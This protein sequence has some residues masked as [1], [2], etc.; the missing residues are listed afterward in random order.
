MEEDLW[1]NLSNT[2]DTNTIYCRPRWMNGCPKI[3]WSG[4]SLKSSINSIGRNSPTA[5]R[6]AAPQPA[7][8]LM[9]ATALGFRQCG[10]RFEAVQHEVHE[11]VPALEAHAAGQ[12][13]DVVEQALARGQLLAEQ[14][15]LVVHPLQHGVGQEG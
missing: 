15:V 7:A 8:I 12:R 2:T 13:A 9:L 3:I 5:I 6:T 4:T 1:P 11:G 10:S 14:R